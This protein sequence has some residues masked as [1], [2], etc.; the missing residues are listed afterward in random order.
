MRA[1]SFNTNDKQCSYGWTYV[2]GRKQYKWRDESRESDG[3]GGHVMQP[4]ILIVDDDL[5][6]CKMLS[7]L[8]ADSGYD[9][10]VVNDPRTVDATLEQHAIDLILLDVKLP[11]IDGF[12]MCTALR[13]RHSQI[14]IIFLTARVEQTDKLQG[15]DQGAD[16][17][18]SKPFEPNELLARIQ[19]VLRRYQRSESNRFGSIIKAGVTSLNLGELEFIDPTR[20]PILLTPTE[21]KLLECLM[22][23]ADLVVSRE[24][25]I[26]RT[27]GYDYDG[28]NN[29]VDVYIR[30]LRRKIEVNPF[31]PQFI[32]T[33]RGTGYVYREQ[34]ELTSTMLG[35]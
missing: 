15:F 13:R 24:L 4:Q 34:R 9:P 6:V 30:R 29:R 23:N 27:W 20:K 18:V 10:I 8:L 22:R 28:G 17:Y 32:H 12:A 33:V 25:L 21:M 3:A 31:E 2:L 35:A 16:D 5:L 11:F 26:E 7:F 19:A 14:P 1:L